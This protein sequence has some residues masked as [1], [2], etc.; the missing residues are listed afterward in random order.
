MTAART[1]YESLEP[2]HVLAYFNPG[3]GDALKDTGVDPSSFYLGARG[4]PLGDCAPEVVISTFYNFA[5]ATVTAGWATARSAGLQKIADRRFAMLDA[6]LRDILGDL[7]D[8]P[9]ITELADGFGRLASDLPLGG[10]ALAA[11]WS[12]STPPNGND[13]LRLWNNVAILREWRGDNHISV[14]VGHGLDGI[15]ACTFH[16]STLLDP[17]IRRRAMGRRLTQLT[18]GWSDTDWEASV[19]RLV[20]R[21]IAERTDDGH[22]LTADGAALYDD[23]EAATDALGENVW[24]APGADDLVA[25][26]RPYVKAVIDAGVLPGTKKKA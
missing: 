25:R 2:F 6:S 16:E 9:E 3:M 8:N 1:A 26:M 14:L 21:G 19:D 23:I 12:T 18:R 13:L 5:P 10:R 17:T 11:A 15:D 20:A 22:R 24:S 7:A 4:A